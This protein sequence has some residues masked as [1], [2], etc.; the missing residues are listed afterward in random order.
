MK[1][2]IIIGGGIAGL[3]AGIFAQK[4]GFASIILE[5]NSTPG[6]QCT[7]WDRK[8]YHIDGC[9]HWLTGTL[10]GTPLNKLWKEVGA[11]QDIEIYHPESFLTYLHEGKIINLY[12]DL[13]KLKAS[14]LEL[15]P[16][17]KAIIEEFC[18]DVKKMHG[19][20]MP[21]GKPSDLM[22]PLEKIGAGSAFLKYGSIISKYLKTD[23]QD[24]ATKY[25]HPGLRALWTSFAPKGYSALMII[26]AMAAFTKGQASIPFGGSRALAERMADRYRELGG[27]YITEEVRELRISGKKV[28]RLF[29]KLE[30]EYSADYVVAA[31]DANFV[32]EKLFYG[33]RNDS[34]YQLRF[35]DPDKYPLSSELLI[36]FGVKDELKNLPRSLRFAIEPLEL[37][38]QRIDHLSLRHF[39][40]EPDFAPP[41]ESILICEI[42]AFAEEI[43][44]WLEYKMHPEEY[45]AE[46]MRVGE[47]VKAAIS[48]RF[49]ELEDKLEL[50]DVVTPLTYQRHCNA[51]RGAFMPFQMKVGGRMLE[52]NGRI[53]GLDNFFLSGQWL[54]PPGGL[55]VA[56]ITGRDTI[57]RICKAERMNFKD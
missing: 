10:S 12:R 15:S 3:S 18:H 43:D 32:Y 38:R 6:G 9:I 28:I 29:T 8:G 37:G 46:K 13:N 51:Y 23:I 47:K 55:P 11:L 44:Y 48:Q 27:K 45:K 49:P 34:Q 21:I 19:F 56:L 16:E 4:N 24:Y 54:Q 36:S 22:N 5:K 31:C 14:W 42:N 41:G 50:L 2:I 1:S 57:M 35:N 33:Q 40:Q 17:D 53:Q 30:N 7:G 39:P 26:F 52:H 20:E 25:K